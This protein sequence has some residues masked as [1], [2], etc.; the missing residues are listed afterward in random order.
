MPSIADVELHCT[1]FLYSTP[2]TSVLT[3]SFP[4]TIFTYCTEFLNVQPSPAG[5]GTE[6]R[7]G[8]RT[9][10]WGQLDCIFSIEMEVSEH[11]SSILEQMFFVI[12]AI[13][14]NHFQFIPRK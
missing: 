2:V 14:Y 5:V 13:I 8:D 3:A 7:G 9:E 6:L 4:S 10:G 12:A 11:F 1:L